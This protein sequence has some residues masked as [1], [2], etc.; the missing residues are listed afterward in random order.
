MN[1]FDRNWSKKQIHVKAKVM[2]NVNIMDILT[3]HQ[4]V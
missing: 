1:I 3:P 4:E 2:S